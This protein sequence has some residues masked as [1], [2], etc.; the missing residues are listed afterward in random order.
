MTGVLQDSLPATLATGTFIMM[1]VIS[2]KFLAAQRP[3]FPRLINA[4]STAKKQILRVRV[5]P[6]RHPNLDKPLPRS[7]S[8]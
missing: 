5:H 7:K 1:V 8:S 3:S 4:S 6:I 2:Q